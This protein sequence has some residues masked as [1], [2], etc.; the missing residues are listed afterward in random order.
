MNHELCAF[1]RILAPVQTT[2]GYGTTIPDCFYSR[3]HLLECLN[4]G[5]GDVVYAFSLRFAILWV[6]YGLEK[7][8]LDLR[9]TAAL[10]LFSWPLIGLSRLIEPA[11]LQERLG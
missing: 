4:I 1:K 11:N 5:F 9:Y 10:M 8:E 7:R 6:V 3:D 2:T